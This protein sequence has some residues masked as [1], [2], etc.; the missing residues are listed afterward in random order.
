MCTDCSQ[1][2]DIIQVT[3]VVIYGLE[4]TIPLMTAELL[5]YPSLATS[6]FRLVTYIAESYPEKLCQMSANMLEAV[7]AS[8]RIAL[9]SYLFLLLFKL[10]N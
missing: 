8:I 3:D 10:F 4:I 6:Y 7:M 5:Q 2:G 9:A 1:P